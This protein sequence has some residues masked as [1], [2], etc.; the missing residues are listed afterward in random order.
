[1]TV[2]SA[3]RSASIIAAKG[4]GPNPSISMTVIPFSMMRALSECAAILP[5]WFRASIAAMHPF[6]AG[7]ATALLFFAQEHEQAG[8]QDKRNTHHHDGSGQFAPDHPAPKDG[9][10]QADIF[11]RGD[12]RGIGQPVGLGKRIADNGRID[13]K[14]KEQPYIAPLGPDPG[15]QKKDQAFVLQPFGM[16]PVPGQHPEQRADQNEH[17][18][19]IDGHGRGL[20]RHPQLAR[21][22]LVDRIGQRRN[23]RQKVDIYGNI[24]RASGFPRPGHDDH[25]DK[26]D[27]H[28]AQPQRPDLFAQQGNTEKSDHQWGGEEKRGRLGQ[29]KDGQRR[30]ERHVRGHDHQAAQNVQAGLIRSQD[31]PA[32]FHLNEDQ[33][34]KDTYGRSREHHLMQGVS[35]RQELDQM[36]FTRSAIG[37]FF[38][39]I[40]V[41]M[42]GGWRILRT[43]QPGLHILRGLMIVTANMTFF[44]ALAV[45]PLAEATA[46]FFA[47]PLMITLLS[48]PLLGE[49]V[50]PLRLGA[51]VV[52][53]VG[54]VIMTRPWE[55]GGARDVPVY[56]YLLPVVAALTYV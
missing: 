22:D 10:R 14:P 6:R 21:Q 23:D 51:V 17:G 40:F 36:V 39:H 12:R 33:T 19:D 29:W 42:E 55:T 5:G 31:S 2:T 1:M 25:A 54:V 13:A 30:K 27:N 8:P 4:P 11:E 41:Q 48:I 50:G 20:G 38:S 43:D 24:A 26:T 49:K 44:A 53:F 7:Q 16:A 35:A 9:Q 46:L 56:I 37:V 3:P 34:E 32:T 47:A 28:R 45:L 52:G 18:L 15:T